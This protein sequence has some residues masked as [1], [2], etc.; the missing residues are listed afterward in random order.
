MAKIDRII[1]IVIALGL[2]ALVLKPTILT[3]HDD[4]GTDRED[5][6]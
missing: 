6:V 1:L 4:D 2:W 3:A 5:E